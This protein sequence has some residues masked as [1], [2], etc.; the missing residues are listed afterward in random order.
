MVVINSRNNGNQT[1]MKSYAFL[2]MNE[3]TNQNTQI[4]EAEKMYSSVAYV[5]N[6]TEELAKQCQYFTPNVCTAMRP[7][8][9][10]NLFFSK[11]KQKLETKDKSNVVYKVKC[12]DCSTDYIGKTTQKVGIRMHQHDYDTNSSKAD[13]KISAISKHVRETDH[14]VDFSKPKILVSE[15][16]HTKLLINEVNQIIKYKETACN[17][18]TDIKS[19]SDSYW[20]L[21]DRF[22]K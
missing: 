11:M 2:S 20:A 15:R 18:K 12:K 8:K 3:T 14:N 22:N 17:D 10:N 19:Y 16:N 5:P 7:V 1:H 9:K 21:I 13:D 6:L 4:N